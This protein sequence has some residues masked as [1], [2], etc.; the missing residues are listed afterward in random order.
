VVAVRIGHGNN[1]SGGG[2]VPQRSIDA[3]ER[4]GGSA[5]AEAYRAEGWTNPPRLELT[6]ESLAGLRD[7]VSP[8]VLHETGHAV[9]ERYRLS[10]GLE[11]EALGRV[12]Y[13]GGSHGGPGDLGPVNERFAD[14]YMRYYLGSLRSD[15]VAYRTI[16]DAIATVP[17]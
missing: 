5:N 2:W 10:R 7:H 1:D 14:G 11:S 3:Y 12:D 4:G 17:E 15:P 8:T 16:S 13:N 6:H 9:D